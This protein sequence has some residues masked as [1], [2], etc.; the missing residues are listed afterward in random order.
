MLSQV[1]QLVVS[2]DGTVVVNI[3]A[4]HAMKLFDRQ[5]RRALEI[6]LRRCSVNNG[7]L[8]GGRGW[9]RLFCRQ[10][11]CSRRDEKGATNGQVSS[12]GTPYTLR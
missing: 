6:L 12:A 3:P 5:G 1:S 7:G 9:N 2:P 10:V 4:G 11:L 8:T